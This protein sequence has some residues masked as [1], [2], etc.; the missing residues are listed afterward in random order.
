LKRQCDNCGVQNLRL[1]D[2]EIDVSES[3]L[4]VKWETFEYVNVSVKGGK[5]NKKLQLVAKETK[6]GILF[7]HLKQLLINFPFHQH[8]ASWQ[9]EQFKNLVSNL[10]LGSCVC[11]HDF[12]KHFRCS[13]L[14]ELQS[15]YFQKTE[16][17]IYVSVIHRHAMLEYDGIDNN[18]ENTNIIT[19]HIYVISPDQQNDHFFVHEVRKQI[20][21]YLK[22][23]SCD[24]TSMHE[25]TDGFPFLVHKSS[26]SRNF[27]ETSHAKGIYR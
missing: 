1:L 27:F 24:I 19:E 23:I 3:A 12:S 10:P 20:S 14:Q 18:E 11:V 13:E 8:S 15:T 22:S 4:N 25:F 9:N 5:T 2:E 17:S 16:V 6:A 7:S 26:F 21:E